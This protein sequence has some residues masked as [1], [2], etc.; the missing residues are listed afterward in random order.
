MPFFSDAD[1]RSQL[2]AIG[3]AFLLLF[4]LACGVSFLFAIFLWELHSE[5]PFT[6]AGPLEFTQSLLLGSSAAL[7]FFEASRRAALRPALVLVGGFFTCMLIR[8]QDYFLDFIQHGCWVY[9]AL[10]TA[11]LC[12]L[13]ACLNLRRTI[14]GLER[15]VRWKYFPYLLI[16][17]VI[18]LAYSRLFG[19]RMVWEAL[20]SDKF[21]YNT[22]TAMEE[23]SELL[24]YLLVLTSAVLA[25]TDKHLK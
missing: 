2:K 3:R 17:V 19:M 11:G 24:G 7:Y 15:F 21:T 8:E 20:L 16:G 5:P 10:A 13:Y 18:V 12:L 23:S 1:V 6:E 4:G 25:N 14:A 22:K 9:P